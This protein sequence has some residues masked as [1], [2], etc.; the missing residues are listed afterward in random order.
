MTVDAELMEIN[1]MFT[2]IITIFRLK[3]MRQKSKLGPGMQLS[4][5]HMP[6]LF[7]ILELLWNNMVETPQL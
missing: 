1:G 2:T 7:I 5:L 6:R 4:I 3:I